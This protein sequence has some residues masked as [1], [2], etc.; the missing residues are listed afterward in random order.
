VLCVVCCV[1]C[2]V[3]YVM[4]DMWCVMCDV[5]CV[6]V[7]GVCVC[8]FV[9]ETQETK[10]IFPKSQEAQ[11]VTRFTSSLLKITKAVKSCWDVRIEGTLPW[12]LKYHSCLH[13]VH[14]APGLQFQCVTMWVVF[15]GF[16]GG[17]VFFLDKYA[18]GIVFWV[19]CQTV[20]GLKRRLSLSS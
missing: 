17:G 9:L 16:F 20:S 2:D 12:R 15:L 7:C 4:C 6:C 13:F 14:W 1:M 11:K 5:W 18:P 10:D 8:V 3:W 19:C